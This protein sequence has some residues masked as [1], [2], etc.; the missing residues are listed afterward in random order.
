MKEYIGTKRLKAAPMNRFEYNNYRGWKTPYDENNDNYISWSP[1][2]VFECTYHEV[3]EAKSTAPFLVTFTDEQKQ[4]LKDGYM[5]TDGIITVYCVP[6]IFEERGDNL[7]MVHSCK[8][9]NEVVE[10]VLES[11][12]NRLTALKETKA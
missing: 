8:D 3:E 2:D 7:Y 10:R 6:S 9:I 12:F 1:K 5:K 11:S 4:V